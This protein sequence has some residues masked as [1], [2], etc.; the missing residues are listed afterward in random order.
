MSKPDGEVIQNKAA[1]KV[2]DAAGQAYICEKMLNFDRILQAGF[3]RDTSRYRAGTKSA[4]T[5]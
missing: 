4:A 1:L 5:W 2:A 3:V